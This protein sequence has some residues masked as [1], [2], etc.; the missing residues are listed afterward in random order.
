MKAEEFIEK[1]GIKIIDDQENNL[2]TNYQSEMAKDLNQFKKEVCEKQREICIDEKDKD[3]K[4]FKSGIYIYIED[5][6]NAPEPN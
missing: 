5:I 2:I 1:W 3:C 6:L 4:Y